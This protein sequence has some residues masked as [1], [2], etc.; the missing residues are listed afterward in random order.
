MNREILVGLHGVSKQFKGP[1]RQPIVVLENVNINLHDGEIVALLGKSGSG[2]S[3]ILRMIAGL[4]PPTSGEVLYRGHAIKGSEAGIS[5][6]FQNFALFPWLDVFENVRLGLEAQKLNTSEQRRRTLEAID[7][8]GLDG[9]ESAY[10]KELSGGMRQRVGFARAVVAAP[11][12]LLMDE[13]FSA[14]DVPTAETLRDDLLDLWQEK[15]IPTRAILMVS[16][17]IEESLLLADRLLILD[18]TPG[19]IKDKLPITLEHPRDRNS[20]HFRSFVDRIYRVI[21]RP[22]VPLFG[23]SEQPGLD[24]RLPGANVQQLLGMLDA[25]REES[26]ND[27]L[28]LSELADE[29]EMELDEVFPLIEALD[30]LDFAHVEAGRLHLA[31][32]GVA[33]LDADILERKVI[34]GHALLE[35]VPLARHIVSAIEAEED[36]KVDEEAFLSELNESLTEE[37]AR[38]V[39]EVVVAWG[40]Y[41]EIFAYDYD[42]GEFS[43]ENPTAEEVS[44]EE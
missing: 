43:L 2:K 4:V 38:R 3:T 10:P 19:R 8:I 11:D 13:P 22:E 18:G 7:M 1:E 44:E 26:D 39:L 40:R 14:L 6:V 16:H 23:M 5:M 29:L 32:Q 37:E 25:V 21:T 35:R 20:T 36:H 30:L 17:G 24:Y 12:V 15:K 34:F 33:F 9:F 42:N 27:R 31:E 41:A 28:E